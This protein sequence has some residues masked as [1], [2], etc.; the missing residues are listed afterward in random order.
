MGVI[1]GTLATIAAIIGGIVFA[2][3]AKVLSS[4]F[5]A[6][7]PRLVDWLIKR[8]IARLPGDLQ[9]RME[10]EWRA[11]INDTPGHIAKIARAYGLSYGAERTARDRKQT[12][13]PSQAERNASQLFGA[14]LLLAMAPLLLA[15]SICLKIERRGPV[16]VRTRSKAGDP[17]HLRFHLGEGPVSELLRRTNLSTLP[18]LFSVLTG[19]VVI[20]WRDWRKGLRRFL[21]I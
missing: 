11:F 10:E 12:A 2:V 3:A 6:W 15:L 20:S 7:S 14:A 19:D 9:P 17:P 1:F 4:E 18:D 21:G 16:I 13:E 5:E 8:A